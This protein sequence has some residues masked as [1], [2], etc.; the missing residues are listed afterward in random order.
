MKAI[1]AENYGPPESLQL[2]EVEKPTPKENEVLVKIHAASLNAHDFEVLG[3]AWT[4]RM[5]RLLTSEHNILGSDVAGRVEAVG[6]NIEQFQPGDEIVGDLLY[7]GLGAFAEFVCAPEK[8]FTL[9]PASMTFEEASTYPQAAIIA[10]QALRDKRPIKPGDKILINGAGGG[11]GTFGI[12]LAKNWGAEVTGVD[13][14]MKLDMMR[15][16]GADHV[17]DYMEEDFTKSGQRYD[18]IIDTVA[19]RSIFKYRRTLSP[20]GLYVMLGGS[21]GAMFQA[22]ILGPLISRTGNKHLGINWWS[23]PYNKEDMDFLEELFE[24]GKVVPVIDKRCPLS[25]VPEALQYLKEGRVL[26]KVV[27]TME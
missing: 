2:K 16:I 11:M 7:S 4:A 24:A 17:I 10:L 3:G 15:S 6:E 19:Q 13:S 1:V 12:Q 23:K 21:R 22:A 26:G 18:V 25:E 9:K 27:I 20:N 8:T 5:G 14:A